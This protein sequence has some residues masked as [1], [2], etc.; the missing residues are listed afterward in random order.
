MSRISNSYV[1]PTP[2]ATPK[3][4]DQ[5]PLFQEKHTKLFS[6]FKLPKHLEQKIS[7]IELHQI[8]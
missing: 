5:K 6:G 1:K 4:K 7:L 8:Q 2:I 3:R